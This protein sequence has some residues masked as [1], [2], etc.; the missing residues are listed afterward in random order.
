VTTVC[1]S[2]NNFFYDKLARSGLRL[3]FKNMIQ[4]SCLCFRARKHSDIQK[5]SKFQV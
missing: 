3:V 1:E 4:L 5:W 2:C